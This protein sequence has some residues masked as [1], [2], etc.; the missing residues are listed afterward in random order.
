ML[1]TEYLYARV[2]CPRPRRSVSLGV[3]LLVVP[4]VEPTLGKQEVDYLLVKTDVNEVTR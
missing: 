1:G 2:R 3:N 4:R